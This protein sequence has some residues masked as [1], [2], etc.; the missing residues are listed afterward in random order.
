MEM[1]RKR[2][3]EIARLARLKFSDE[4]LDTF[5]GQFAEI[6]SFVEQLNEVDTS[7][8]EAIHVHHRDE[9]VI[10]K[11]KVIKGFTKEEV[12][13]NAPDKDEDYFLVPKVISGEEE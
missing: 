6:L 8:V 13:M 4:E 9:N 7:S 1:D 3:E 11:D 10:S 2:V 5:T 12:L